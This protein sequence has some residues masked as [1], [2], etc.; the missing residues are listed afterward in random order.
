VTSAATTDDAARSWLHRALAECGLDASGAVERVHVTA[1]ST[2]SRV[3]T[4]Q[5]AVWFKENGPGSAYEAALIRALGDWVPG[6]V[7]GPLAVDT[8][9]GWSLL[10]DGG[11]TLRSIH[12]ESPDGTGTDRLR[13]WEAMLGR[14]AELQRT[15][16]ERVPD[17]LALGVPDMRPELMPDRL[18]VLLDDPVVWA[19]LA[20]DRYEAVRR[21]QPEYARW[22][23]E[24]AAD[25]IPLSLQHDDLHDANVFVSDGGYR[26]FDW[27]DASVAHPFG[28]LLIVLRAAARRFDLKPADTALVRLRDAYLEPWSE[29]PDRAGLVRTADTAVRVAKVGRALAWQRA[30]LGAG[31][32]GREQHGEAVPRWVEQLVEPDIL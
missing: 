15:L 16:A 25:G 8:E 11:A 10:P 13:Q 28:S 20:P 31:P 12:A 27:G 21:M 22:C 3:P 30:L 1:W 19:G 14:Y 18:D 17:L 2:V 24:L 29:G 32:T 7:I 4:R 5:G 9:R 23:A 26:F 6:H